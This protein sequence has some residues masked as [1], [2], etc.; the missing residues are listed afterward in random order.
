MK[1]YIIIGRSGGSIMEKINLTL[2]ILEENT[3]FSNLRGY[4]LNYAFKINDKHLSVRLLI[5]S[6]LFLK[7]QMPQTADL[8]NGLANVIDLERS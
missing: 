7:S 1:K 6:A 4:T 3:L 5:R 2:W 8:K